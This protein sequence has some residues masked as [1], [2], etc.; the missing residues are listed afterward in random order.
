MELN[1][2]ILIWILMVFFHII[3]DFCLQQVLAKLKQKKYWLDNYPQEIYENDYIIAL[4]I[5]AFEWCV[6]IHLPIVIYLLVGYHDIFLPI[7]KF[8]I[9]ICLFIIQMIIHA[10]VD[11]LKANCLKISLLTDQCIH[12]IQITI[13]WCILICMV[14]A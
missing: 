1:K 9:F 8:D 13:S 5:H 2:G 7:Q 11:H 12:L 3:D 6:M 14:T 10:I 4:I